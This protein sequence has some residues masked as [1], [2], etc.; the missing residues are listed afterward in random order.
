[1]EFIADKQTSDELNL[2]GK[3]Q[4]GSV[5]NLFNKVKTRGG[6]RL[7]EDFFRHPLT[8]ARAIN[9]RAAVF[10]YFQQSGYNFPLDGTVVETFRRWIDSGG[11]QTMAG[12]ALSSIKNKVFS[13]V[14]HDERYGQQQ[15]GIH[16]AA[17]VLD[18][19]YIF[20][21]AIDLS[22]CPEAYEEK[23]SAIKTTLSN[24]RLNKLR[25]FSQAKGLSLRETIDYNH[26]LKKTL[27]AD[28][29]AILLFIYELDVY[30][31]VGLLAKNKEFNYAVAIADETNEHSNELSAT[32]LRHPCLE[33]AVGN[34]LSLGIN[35][36]VLF[37]TGANMAGKSTLM[38][39][40]GIA[41]CLAHMGFPVAVK[42]M[43]FSVRDGLY[44]SINVSDNIN[45][46]FSHFY[47]EVLRV[48]RA[49]ELV[50]GGKNMLVMFD[51]LFKGTNVKDAYEGTLEVTK[52]FAK[53]TNCLFIIST[54]IIEVGEALNKMPNIL[55][56]YMPTLMDGNRPVYIY[57]LQEGI[58]EDRQGMLIIKNEGI[59]ELLGIG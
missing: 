53:Y 33:K 47:A 50:S 49:A 4:S 14:L 18:C 15:A 16:A 30:I 5:C 59:L 17:A 46:G 32:D 38:K 45:Q 27:I 58:T 34:D 10:R 9:E 25:V 26:L 55:F 57:K 48:K 6:E 11:S 3:Y 51:E 7:L 41:I 19:L 54:H 21:S 43:R 8:D 29:E 36:N 39:S 44:S 1:M 40:V 52:A 31:S 35:S 13:S 20:L 2:L 28:M 12:S 22:A 37:L 24:Q 23:L 56:G 42:E